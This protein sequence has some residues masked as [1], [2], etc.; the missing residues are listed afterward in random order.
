[1]IPMMFE[2]QWIGIISA[3]IGVVG[4]REYGGQALFDCSCGKQWSEGHKGEQARSERERI[5]FW[6]PATRGDT[7]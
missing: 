4:C 2:R 5:E 7:E 3:Y 1:M 6:T